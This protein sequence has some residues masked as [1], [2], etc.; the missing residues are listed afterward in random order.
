[1]GKRPQG[2]ISKEIS[3][4][5]FILASYYVDDG[6]FFSAWWMVGMY[7]LWWWV[8]E[9]YTGEVDLVVKTTE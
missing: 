8:V 2:Y 1:M 3:F 4:S 6:G 5:L 7:W 9:E